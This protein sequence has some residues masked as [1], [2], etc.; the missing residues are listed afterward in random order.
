MTICAKFEVKH[1]HPSTNAHTHW[2]G[3]LQVI[4]DDHKDILPTRCVPIFTIRAFNGHK[5]GTSTSSSSS[6]ALSDTSIAGL[7]VQMT[8]GDYDIYG[9]VAASDFDEL[10]QNL[11]VPNL[12]LDHLVR[13]CISR[14]KPRMLG[15]G[16]VA[17]SNWLNEHQLATS[18][19]IPIDSTVS[20]DDELWWRAY[21]TL[22]RTTA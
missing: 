19:T 15:D 3:S 5:P 6:N 20:T 13:F 10:I 14:L 16:Q 8:R 9:Q 7:D 21:K 22:L 1:Q 17:L 2:E 12:T 18:S 11:G 4:V